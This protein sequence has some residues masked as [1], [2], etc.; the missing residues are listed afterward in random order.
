MRS[1]LFSWLIVFLVAAVCSHNYFTESLD[2]KNPSLTMRTS[3]LRRNLHLFTKLH[4]IREGS[5][6][7]DPINGYVD[8][9]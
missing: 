2:E 7:Y 1:A 3:R 6:R 4:R 8:Y 5:K 9:L